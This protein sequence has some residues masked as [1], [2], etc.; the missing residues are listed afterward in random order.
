MA[1]S[2][3]Y[4][5]TSVG[6]QDDFVTAAAQYFACEAGGHNS[7]D[8]CPKNYE[9]FT[10]P[11]LAAA[12][13]LLMGLIPVI[14]MI[15]VIHFGN[16]RSNIIRVR[17]MMVHSLSRQR[18]MGMNGSNGKCDSSGKS[19]SPGNSN[20]STFSQRVVFSKRVE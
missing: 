14:N 10:H 12:T 16:A 9:Q 11:E 4:F 17:T 7:S 6:D 18:R 5:G 20:Q 3:A 2:L 8:P 15:Y 13:Y 19:D 1:V